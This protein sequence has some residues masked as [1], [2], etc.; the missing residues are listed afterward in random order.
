MTLKTKDFDCVE[1][2]NEIQA[3]L[4]DEYLANKDKYTSYVDF[5]EERA[6]NSP[7][8]QETIRRFKSASVK[9]K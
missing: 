2:K 4:Y 3:R 8:V 9:N 1:M 7:W 5:I 6:K